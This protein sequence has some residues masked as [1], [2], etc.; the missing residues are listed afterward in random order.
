MDISSELYTIIHLA[1]QPE[2]YV[3]PN[4]NQMD[5]VLYKLSVDKC[6]YEKAIE[7]WRK[8]YHNHVHHI[9]YINHYDLLVYH[10]CPICLEKIRD[11][12]VIFKCSHGHL[13]HNNCILSN[14]ANNC[15]DANIITE[16]SNDYHKSLL[17]KCPLCR[18]PN[19]YNYEVGF[20]MK[21]NLF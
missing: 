20:I 18:S 13:F 9:Q 2:Y 19:K 17:I 1:K 5:N 21:N 15:K 16:E 10:D 7:E 11:G 6:D 12:Q 8:L 14:I 4:R 3:H